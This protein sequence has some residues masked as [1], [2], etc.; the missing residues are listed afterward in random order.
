MLMAWSRIGPARRKKYKMTND[1]HILGNGNMPDAAGPEATRNSN[2][3]SQ[4][5]NSDKAGLRKA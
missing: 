3:V 2:T 4:T 5:S 1:G